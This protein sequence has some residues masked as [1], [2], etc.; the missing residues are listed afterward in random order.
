MK[1]P[2]FLIA[3]LVFVVARVAAQAPDDGEAALILGATHYESGDREAHFEDVCSHLETHPDSRWI[4]PLLA[5]ADSLSRSAARPAR[6]IEALERAVE[7]RSIDGFVR[8]RIRR[9]LAGHYIGAN[10]IDDA[11][12][13]LRG[14]GLVR[15]FRTLGPIGPRVGNLHDIV[16]PPERGESSP[17]DRWAT[18]T[19]PAHATAGSP[20][21]NVDAAAPGCVYLAATVSLAKPGAVALE[22][23]ARG[24]MKLWFDSELAFDVDRR[25]GRC[26][27]EHVA[28]FEAEG[29]DHAILIK[30]SEA[31]ED[32]A[33]RGAG[34]VSLRISDLAGEPLE[35]LTVRGSAGG[36][37]PGKAVR[38]IPAKPSHAF[39]ERGLDPAALGYDEKIL[40]AFELT[41]EGFQ[42]ECVALLAGLDH[43]ARPTGIF[44]ADLIA[45]NEYLPEAERHDRAR[46]IAESVL[47]RSPAHAGA[48]D[49]WARL[50]A[51]KDRPEEALKRLAAGLEAKP[52]AT[53]LLVSELAVFGRLKW[54]GEYDTA[55][56][57]ALARASDH[58]TFVEAQFSRAIQALDAK[59]VAALHERAA[60]LAGDPTGRADTRL[61]EALDRRD[62][63]LIRELASG[64]LARAADEVE[65]LE[66]GAAIDVE[67][68]RSGESAALE[69]AL[70]SLLRWAEIRPFDAEPYG[71]RA[72]LL[73]EAGREE[74]ALESWR[75]SLRRNPVQDAVRR[76]VDQPRR[77]AREAIFAEFAID[78]VQAVAEAKPLFDGEYK[79]ASSV[80]LIDQM[81]TI[82]EP[83]GFVETETH[84]LVRIGD[85][86]GVQRWSE[87]AADGSVLALRT[88]LP[89]G[90]SLEPVGRDRFTMP[91]LAPGTLVEKRIRTHGNSRP[92]EP[93]LVSSFLFQDTTVP[94]G[95]PYHL[96]R[97]VVVLPKD[98]DLAL[99]VARFDG[100]KT[101][102]ERGDRTVHVLTKRRV[103]RLEPEMLMPDAAE[104]VARARLLRDG[105]SLPSRLQTIEAELRDSG[106]DDRV[107][108]PAVLAAAKSAAGDA[109]GDTARAKAAYDWVMREIKSEQGAS[110]PDLVLAEKKGA[111]LP[112]LRALFEALGIACCDRRGILV[113]DRTKPILWNELTAEDFNAEFLEISPKDGPPLY[114]QANLRGVPF[115]ELPGAFDGIWNLALTG[116]GGAVERLPERFDRWSEIDAI[117]MIVGPDRTE[118]SLRVALLGDLGRNLKD[119]IERLPEAR[120]RRVAEDIAGNFFRGYSPKVASYAMVGLDAVDATFEI[121]ARLEAKPLVG[122]G[123]DSLT[124]RPVLSPLK[125]TA[126]LLQGK[127]SRTHPLIIGAGNR[128]R[129]KLVYEPAP[130]YEF[131]SIPESGSL[132]TAGATYSLSFALD[133][134]KLVV[135]RALVLGPLRVSPDGYAE[136]VKFLRGIDEM[137]TV[138]VTLRAPGKAREK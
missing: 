41:L 132:V 64:A 7:S 136:F 103:P 76:L 48:L 32:D 81:I 21:S 50:R 115:G 118:A 77:A 86:N 26:A 16:G 84:Q 128:N 54:M 13:L 67:L 99:D 117:D 37:L 138:R 90:T 40:R 55:L 125:L 93:R 130:G 133:G 69:R 20:L 89:D 6:L 34:N 38:R 114:V 33:D 68:W 109:L 85:K 49:V 116:R 72:A 61:Q 120:R 12:R 25:R 5:L 73:V 94:N 10:R 121:H 45:A 100:E 87:V 102:E 74:E 123:D 134:R 80:V 24:S 9:L 30:L 112:L 92:G 135:E 127:A 113:A 39:L 58:G 2:S 131:E 98:T 19:L 95:A 107:V 129:V 31:M 35:G 83:D 28:T 111:R 15:D 22:L 3:A 46:R 51:E 63:P 57:R 101:S 23:G 14:D 91:G 36:R 18:F 97:W 43:A 53:E 137:E 47:E 42:P 88:I 105:A 65:A 70:R 56:D 96:T 119:G 11:K 82:V 124:M 106:G 78:P 62:V 4:R 44:A 59:R 66:L 29:G 79:K 17:N 126:A 110:L 108:T 8:D 122:R 104:L 27:E 52:G 71:R 1:R 60:M 75:E